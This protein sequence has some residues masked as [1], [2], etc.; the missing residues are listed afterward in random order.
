[1]YE[2]VSHREEK[3]SSHTHKTGPWYLLEVLFKISNKHPCPF[4]M[5]VPPWDCNAKFA[6]LTHLNAQ[7]RLEYLHNLEYL[8]KKFMYFTSL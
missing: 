1:M 8:H 7:V 2:L 3:T 4:Y 6:Y 5:G